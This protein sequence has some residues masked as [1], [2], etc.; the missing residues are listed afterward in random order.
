[1]A[2]SKKIWK[3]GCKRALLLSVNYEVLNFVTD[4]RAVVMTLKGR[5][6]VISTWDDRSFSTPTCKISTPA[7]IRLCEPIRRKNGPVRYHR[8]VV[9]RRDGWLCQYCGR[10]LSRRDATIDHVIPQSKGGKTNYKN[11]VT[12][13]K[14]CNHTKAFKTPEEAGMVLRTKPSTPNILHLYNVDR[15]GGWH[16]EWD[17]YLGHLKETN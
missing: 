3:D 9:F 5:A 17:A 11:C 6:E 4:W 15:R 10:Q 8:V 16:P 7:T 1:M 14:K 2:K 13:C 12:A